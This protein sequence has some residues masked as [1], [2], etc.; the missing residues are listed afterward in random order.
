[1]TTSRERAG[2]RVCE[3]EDIRLGDKLQQDRVFRREGYH[4]V[5]TQ[6]TLVD[7]VESAKVAN[8]KRAIFRALARL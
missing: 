5:R 7:V 6:D 3:R 8:I 1:M 2:G 4:A